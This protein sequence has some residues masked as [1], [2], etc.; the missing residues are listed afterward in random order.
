MLPCAAKLDSALCL[1]EARARER[2]KRGRTVR[3]LDAVPR[4]L[5]LATLKLLHDFPLAVTQVPDPAHLPDPVRAE[6]GHEPVVPER[7][8]VVRVRR[9]LT[10]VGHLGVRKDE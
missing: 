4:S 7:D 10:R 1:E 9:L 8:E 3:M 6:V 2:E 5:V